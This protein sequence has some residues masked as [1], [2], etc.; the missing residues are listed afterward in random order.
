MQ[1]R[2]LAT[3]QWALAVFLSVF[4]WGV[5]IEERSFTV[6][7][8]L[9]VS[10]PSLPAGFMVL[11]R[12]EGVDS[13]TV[14]FKGNGIEVL[15]D[16]LTGNPEAVRLS[17]SIIDQAGDFPFSVSRE[18]TAQDVVYSGGPFSRLVPESF[19]PSSVMLTVDRTMSRNLPVAVRTASDIPERYYW[20]VAQVEEVE[21]RGAVSVLEHLDSL[22]TQPVYPDSGRTVASI[23]RPEGIV[24]MSPSSITLELV[25]PVEVVA[26]IR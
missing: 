1:L 3:F 24:Y 10:G 18:F 16:Q 22:S 20:R 4:L 26:K 12:W 15:L 8:E 23:V 5:S 25:P 2:S 6:K 17:I 14:S 9:P 19:S 13:V 11:D 7:R 21:V